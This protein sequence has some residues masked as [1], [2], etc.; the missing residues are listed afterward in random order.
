MALT[1]VV[2][3]LAVPEHREDDQQVAQDVHHGGDDEHREQSGRHPGRPRVPGRL[4]AAR[5][6]PAWAPGPSVR[7]AAV[8]EGSVLVLG[9]RGPSCA[10]L[11]PPPLAAA[12][13]AAPGGA[14]C[15]A[16]QEA[17]G[18]GAKRDN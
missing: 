3:E 2:A 11:Q 8:A 13:G 16:R 10:A 4:P 14:L 15:T 17:S 9:H 18:E 12:R 5:S 1:C 7:L 6:G